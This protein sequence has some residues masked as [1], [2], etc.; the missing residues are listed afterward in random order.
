MRT[1][2]N[3]QVENDVNTPTSATESRN[4]V[5]LL[6]DLFERERIAQRERGVSILE[7]QLQS[8]RS[9]WQLQA[10]PTDIQRLTPA[11]R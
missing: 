9:Q 10:D 11:A 7:A 4:L 6:N 1:Y 8:L 2:A 3:G 5:G